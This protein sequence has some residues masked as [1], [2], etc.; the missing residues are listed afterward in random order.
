MAKHKLRNSRPTELTTNDED[1]I[2]YG[3]GVQMEKLEPNPEDKFAIKECFKNSP[4]EYMRVLTPTRFRKTFIDKE[5]T[6]FEPINQDPW[7]VLGNP[8][9]CRS[10]PEAPGGNRGRCPLSPI[11]WTRLYGRTLP[12]LG[13]VAE[14]AGT[15]CNYAR[16]ESDHMTTFQYRLTTSS[17]GTERLSMKKSRRQAGRDWIKNQIELKEI[18]LKTSDSN[19]KILS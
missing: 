8:G 10:Y 18:Y 13:Q 16:M 3:G 17:V 11:Y 19:F 15:P 5:P 4:N 12:L 2:M 9:H 6:L 14:E 7:K 1:M